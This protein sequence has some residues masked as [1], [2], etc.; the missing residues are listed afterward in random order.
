MY[1]KVSIK[2]RKEIV[3]EQFENTILQNIN[4]EWIDHV[5]L[6]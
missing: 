3:K 5:N 4:A 1:N 6:T 2:N